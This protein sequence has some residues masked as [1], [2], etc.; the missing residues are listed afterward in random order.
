MTAASLLIWATSIGAFAQTREVEVLVPAFQSTDVSAD[1]EAEQVRVAIETAVAASVGTSVARITE[2]PAVGDLAAVDYADSCPP[3]EY[4]GCAFVLGDAGS[5][6]LAVAGVLS[7]GSGGLVRAEIHVIDIPQT[8][9]LVSFVGEYDPESGRDSFATTVAAV[10]RAAA[11][12]KVKAGGDIRAAAPVLDASD[13][14][15]QMA[16]R[17]LDQLSK[18]IGGSDQVGDKNLGEFVREEYT[19]DDM[20]SDMQT[21][22]SKPWDRLGMTPQEYLRYKNSGLNVI[23]WRQRKLGRK[24]QLL[25]RGMAGYGKGPTDGAYYGRQ[26][27]SADDV[28]VISET[29][30]WHS[31]VDGNAPRAGLELAYG[32][33]PELEVGFQMGLSSGRYTVDIQT[34]TEGQYSNPNEPDELA[35]RSLWYGGQA[36]FAPFPVL[37]VRPV[38]GMS[39]TTLRGRSISQFYDV[40]ES[41]PVFE[42]PSSTRLGFILGG[43]ARISRSVDFFLHAPLH[44][45]VGGQSGSVLQEGS[46]VLN[47]N[48][49]ARPLSSAYAGV[50]A[51]IQ[52]RLFGAALDRQPSDFDEDP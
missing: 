21:D 49:S 11:E 45:V 34:V 7:P 26:A 14:D 32:I 41:L 27:R 5:V 24:G 31:M 48:A 2:V 44:L 20:A 18:E 22:G 39:F 50:Q 15:K 23:E 28:T 12:G 46:G 19:M 17:Q 6:S 36:L 3:G 9:D 52:V 29:Y 43:E 35:N 16:G 8:V 13:A 1:A 33:L 37:P 38:V 51:G 40:G 47:T 10:V 25:I 4:V 42:R 30:A